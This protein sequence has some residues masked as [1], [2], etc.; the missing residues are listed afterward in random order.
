MAD[1]LLEDRHAKS[2]ARVLAVI[3]WGGAVMQLVALAYNV[4]NQPHP[5]LESADWFVSFFTNLTN[6]LLAV[7]LTG[8]A[9][10]PRT[11]SPEGSRWSRR[12]GPSLAAASVVYIIVVGLIYVLLLRPK[13]GP[14]G[15]GLLADV[16]MHYAMPIGYP[17]FW[18]KCV[19]KCDLKPSQSWY[20][21]A[22]PVAYAVA[23]EV[24]GALTG[25]YPYPFLDA[26]HMGYLPVLL[27]AAGFIV[28]FKLLGL[29]V[30]WADRNLKGP[31]SAERAHP[32]CGTQRRGNPDLP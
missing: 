31:S 7:V 30:V 1:F 2:I 13:N 24:R 22:Y 32:E 8:V 11:L 12:I 28:L 18:L 10:R 19:R 5:I 16:I 26:R 14:G 6:S 29:A 15:L 17:I 23:T 21:L 4:R 27:N 9:L 3:A 25:W 20:W